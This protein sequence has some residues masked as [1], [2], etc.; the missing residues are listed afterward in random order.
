MDDQ[1]FRKFFEEFLYHICPHCKNKIIM[2]S[3]HRFKKHKLNSGL[4][5]PYSNQPVQGKGFKCKEARMRLVGK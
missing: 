1:E 5:C 4:P 3:N 2:D